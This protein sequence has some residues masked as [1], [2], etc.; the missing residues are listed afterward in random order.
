MRERGRPVRRPQNHPGER[1]WRL[2][3]K[4]VVEVARR[5]PLE[6]TFSGLKQ[7]IFVILQSFHGQECG[8]G[9]AGWFWLRVFS[10][11]IITKH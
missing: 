11:T 10:D 9:L 8:S 3:E 1:V 4:M 2:A 5:D 7:E 6:N